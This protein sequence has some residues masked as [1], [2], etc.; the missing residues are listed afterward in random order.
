[1]GAAPCC[2]HIIA[3]LT[4]AKSMLMRVSAIFGGVEQAEFVR[5]RAGDQSR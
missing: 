3:F 4:Q 5:Q 2:V 1:M